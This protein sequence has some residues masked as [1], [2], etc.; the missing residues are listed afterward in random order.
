MGAARLD[1]CGAHGLTPM[2]APAGSSH[3]YVGWWQRRHEELF[4][5]RQKRRPLDRPA[6]HKRRDDPVV[7]QPGQERRRLP[8]AFRAPSRSDAR[9]EDCGQPAAS[10]SSW[11]RSRRG[12]SAGSRPVRTV[13]LAILRVLGRR[14]HASAR[15]PGAPFF[16]SDDRRFLNPSSSARCQHQKGGAAAAAGGRH[17]SRMRAALA[18]RA[19]DQNP[20]RR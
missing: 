12:N 15:S 16:V 3:N 13:T 2:A 19:D 1:R 4:D 5:P 10:C 6:Q 20:C 7:A 8:M 18:R 9:L 11:P 14:R 17:S